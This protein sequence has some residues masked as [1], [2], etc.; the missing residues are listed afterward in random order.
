V[1][2]AIRRFSVS[3]CTAPNVLAYESFLIL[4]KILKVLCDQLL[5]I[6]QVQVA[7]D[8][9][10]HEVMPPILRLQTFSVHQRM[11]F[12]FVIKIIIFGASKPISACCFRQS[13]AA[14]YV[15]TRILCSADFLKIK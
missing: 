10:L 12:I 6:L 2:D 1:K 9:N 5:M 8:I 14:E 11:F 15:S 13:T 3:T 4:S 7:S